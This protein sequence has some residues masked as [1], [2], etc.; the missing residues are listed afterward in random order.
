MIEQVLVIALPYSVVSA[1]LIG[2]SASV[3]SRPLQPVFIIIGSLWTVLFPA[4]IQLFFDLPLGVA[5]AIAMI[6]HSVVLLTVNER[7]QG[8]KYWLRFIYLCIIVPVIILGMTDDVLAIVAA[9][10]GNILL[11]S[12]IGLSVLLYSSFI[13]IVLMAAPIMKWVFACVLG[14]IGALSFAGKA[15]LAVGGLMHLLFRPH[16]LPLLT[17]VVLATGAI[18]TVV[19]SALLRGVLTS[20]HE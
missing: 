16:V 12:G 6:A 14:A 17:W 11:I 4:L 3:L 19:V 15:G 2:T 1:L 8:E 18:S 13:I 10:E 20:K 5:S 9:F 7:P